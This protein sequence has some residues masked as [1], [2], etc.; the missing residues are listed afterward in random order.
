MAAQRAEDRLA[1]GFQLR[2][3]AHIFGR[4][5]AAQ[6][7]GGE[8]DPAL[9]AGAEHRRGRSQRAVPGSTLCCCEP[10]WNERPC[11]IRPALWA[12]SRISAAN[13]GSQQHNVEAWD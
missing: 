2:R 1:V 5:A 8:H 7:D 6:I 13:S 11:A 12:R 3:L 10:T 4:E 9:G